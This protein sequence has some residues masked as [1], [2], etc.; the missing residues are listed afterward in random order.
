MNPKFQSLV[1]FAMS[2]C[3]LKVYDSSLWMNL[4]NTPSHLIVCSRMVK[5]S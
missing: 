1:S 3:E 2:G 5:E 4:S